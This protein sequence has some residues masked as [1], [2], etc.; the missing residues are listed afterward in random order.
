MYTYDN[1]KIFLVPLDHPSSYDF[2][3]RANHEIEFRRICTYLINT[4]Y[5][6]GNIIDSGAWVGDNVIPWAMNIKGIVYGIDPSA[7]NCNF[8]NMMANLN[9]LDNIRLFPIALADKPAILQSSGNINHCSFVTGLEGAPT[10]QA[11]A[12]SLDV[13]LTNRLIQDIDFIHLDVEGFEFKAIIGATQL[14]EK[15][16]PIIAFEQHLDVDDYK[17][18]SAH[19]QSMGY[20]VYIIN[21]VLKGCNPDC[22]NLIAFPARLQLDV[23][24]IARCLKNNDLLTKV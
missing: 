8:I 5:I 13:M 20:E 24:N 21:E 17:G 10:I 22:R 2:R 4:G 6:K 19:L 12:L 11:T 9:K 15:Y 18:I 7:Y 23:Q 16:K 1:N 3:R 14:I